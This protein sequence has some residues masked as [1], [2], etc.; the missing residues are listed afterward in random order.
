M[1]NHFAMPLNYNQVIEGS[2]RELRERVRQREE[3]DKRIGQLIKALH[4]LAPML[5]VSE[6]SGLFSSVKIARRK[7][8]GLTEIILDILRDSDVPLS[9]SDIRDRMQES[10]FDLSKYS[11]ASATIHNIMRRLV[12]SKRAMPTF[13]KDRVVLYKLAGKEL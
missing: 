10:G 13:S 12:Q 7:G 9:V 8:L 2:L 3:A 4:D 11:R 6:R 1:Q 5:P